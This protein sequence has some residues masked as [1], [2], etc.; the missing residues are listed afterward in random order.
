M[1]ILVAG[2]SGALGRRLVPMLVARGHEVTGLTRSREKVTLVEGLGAG[3]IVADVLDADATRSAVE[4]AKPETIVSLLTNLPQRLDLRRINET[5]EANNRV[6]VTGTTNL[7]A[8]ATA[9]GVGRLVVESLAIWY[10]PN[11]NPRNE[12]APLFVDA[13]EPVG[14]A[15]RALMEMERIAQA[16]PLSTIVLRYGGF[17]G[18]GT[19]LGRGGFIYEDTLQRKYPVLGDGAGYYSWIHVDDA[20]TATVA[21]VES[22]ETGIFNVVDDEPAQSRDWLPFYAQTI[23]APAPRTIPLMVARFVGGGLVDW[24]NQI[25]PVSNARIKSALGWKPALPSWREGFRTGL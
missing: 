16:A 17:Y 4:R 8:S 24:Q 6:R 7:V 20:A 10:A 9:A 22:R 21:A 3:A 18:P 14:T 15:V 11:P 5:Y 23:G 19:W 12:Q 1:R 25:P 2:A 13:P